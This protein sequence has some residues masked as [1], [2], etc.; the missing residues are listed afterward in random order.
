MKVME[1]QMNRQKSTKYTVQQRR[2]LAVYS[3]I[4]GRRPISGLLATQLC[5]LA[6]LTLA[7]AVFFGI[8][9]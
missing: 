4:G 3:T 9:G 8:R 1:I 6:F 7:I 5:V 2:A